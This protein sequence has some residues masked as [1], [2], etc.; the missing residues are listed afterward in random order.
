MNLSRLSRDELQVRGWNGK[1]IRTCVE[2]PKEVCH[3]REVSAWGGRDFHG[4]VFGPGGFTLL[5]SRNG[6]DESCL[7]LS[8]FSRRTMVRWSNGADG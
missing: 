5:G 2:N 8:D 4:E 7:D 6:V 3:P 1:G